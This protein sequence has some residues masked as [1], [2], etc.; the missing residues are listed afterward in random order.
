V[1]QIIRTIAILLTVWGIVYISHALDY[2]QYIGF[3]RITITPN[4]HGAIFLASVLTLAFLLYP[5][6]KGI[7]KIQWYNWIFV[8]LGVVPN[9]YVVIFYDSWQS[10]AGTSSTLVEAVLCIA[11]ILALLEGLR[12][13]V[14]IV[15]P[16][17]TLFFV[18]HPFVSNYLPGILFGRGYSL[19][20]ITTQFFLPSGDGI[21][22]MPLEIAA[23]I[24]IAFLLF[25]QMFMAS[26]GG[27]TIM[28][29]ALSIV[30]HVRGG[31]AKAAVVASG[32]FGSL[33]GSPAS[34]VATTGTFTIPM[35]KKMGYSPQFAAA[36]EASASNGGQLLPPVMGVAAFVMAEM[37]RMKYVE[38]CYVAFI[39]AILYY[40]FVF[41]QVDFEAGRKRLHGLPIS[42][43]PSFKNTIKNGYIHLVP[44]IVLIYFLFFLRRSPELSAFWATVSIFLVTIFSK[45]TRLGLS[46]ITNALEETGK[47]VIIVGLS[48]AMAGLMMGSVSLTAIALSISGN[49]V[50][51]AGGN[52][53]LLLLLAALASFVFGMGMTSIPC[54]IFV[55][56]MVAPALEQMGIRTIGAHLFVFWLAI[57]SFITPP[58]CLAAYVAAAISKTSPMLTGV[59]ATRL[60]IGNFIIPFAFIYNPGLILNDTALNIALVI[61]F[62]IVGIF[63]IAVGFEGYLFKKLSWWQR[64]LF[65]INGI[66]LFFPNW[67]IRSLVLV[68]LMPFVVLQFKNRN[69]YI[70]VQNKSKFYDR[71]LK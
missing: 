62:T 66:L 2:L 1:V 30:G 15:L 29:L 20:R 28:N 71:P 27:E 38:V 3:K 35:M 64:I 9:A 10:H 6:K 21:F 65:L 60:G 37:L 26:G 39:P 55:A 5:A 52:L 53:F 40:I 54:Y 46:K 23:T 24:V 63:S 17:V 16:I 7:N 12:R 19:E 70:A 48:C 49:I 69:H 59:Y 44:V 47:F 41:L 51:F 61:I 25:G 68:V 36:V 11:L 14:G 13:V 34:N 31:S 45:K 22:G 8:I 42:E 56:I 33:S 58:V 32:L 4:Q 67:W 57:A 43:L 50:N 18:I